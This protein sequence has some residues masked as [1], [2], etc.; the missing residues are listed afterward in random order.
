[1]SGMIYITGQGYLLLKVSSLLSIEVQTDQI[2][3]YANVE[4]MVAVSDGGLNLEHKELGKN[5]NIP[6]GTAWYSI[7]P[8]SSIAGS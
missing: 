7:Q 1:M 2:V 8:V 4:L 6:T 5:V 3:Q